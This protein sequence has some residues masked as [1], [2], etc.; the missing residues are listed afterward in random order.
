M[1]DQLKLR[2]YSVIAICSAVVLCT[3]WVLDRFPSRAEAA[4]DRL[5]IQ[6][7]NAETRKRVDRLEDAIITIKDDNGAIRADVSFIKGALQSKGK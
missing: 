1:A 2:L 5:A 4:A 6:Q 3:V 7:E